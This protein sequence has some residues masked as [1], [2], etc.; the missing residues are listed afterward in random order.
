LSAERLHPQIIVTLDRSSSMWLRPSPQSS[1][2]LVVAQRQ[3]RSIMEKYRW[4]VRFGYVEFP[5]KACEAGGCCASQVAYPQQ[6]NTLSA[7]DGIWSCRNLPSS[8]SETTDDAPVAQ[9]LKRV[10]NHFEMQSS[11]SESRYVLLLTDG[12]P[13]CAAN[14]AKN[15][16]AL[17]ATEASMIAALNAQLRVIGL[18]AELQTSQCLAEIAAKGVPTNA[19]GMP[20]TAPSIA[21]DGDKLYDQLNNWLSPIS[22]ESC[23]FRFSTARES[24]TVKVFYDRILVPRDTN[25]KNGWD[26][27]NPTQPTRITL[28]GDACDEVRQEGDHDLDFEI[29]EP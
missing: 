2:R 7:I 14:V 27:D 22:R 24:P 29:C 16:C 23:S 17:A 4:M 1:S 28:Y 20:S 6:P 26:L 12:E 10:R 25:R 18:S 15:D 19:T 13:S 21:T 11:S 3:L 9:A 5:I 8:C